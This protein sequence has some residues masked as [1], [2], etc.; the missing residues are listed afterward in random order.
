MHARKF[1]IQGQPA[2][3]GDIRSIVS[4]GD[5][6]SDTGFSD[7]HGFGRSSNGPTWVEY[8]AERL[9]ARLT[10]LAWGGART[11]QGNCSGPKDWSG[12]SWQIERHAFDGGPESTL[13]TI[14]A[15]VNDLFHGNGDPEA[16][17]ARLVA[18]QER[19]LEK[20][21]RRILLLTVPDLSRAPAY[22]TQKEYADARRTVH[23]HTL[24]VNARLLDRLRP[25]PCMLFD[26]AGFLEH[27]LDHAYRDT[28]AAWLGSYA[29][30]DPAGHFWWDDWHPMTSVHERLAQA[31][32]AA[33]D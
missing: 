20:G 5:S 18:A 13:Y 27:L 10:C 14:L 7:G 30:P 9:G 2:N 26:A 17:A 29:F 4:F 21:A 28:A 19:L 22:R 16:T 33:G 6:L 1:W 15:G 32:G 12:L 25:G 8:L 31:V 23:E 11:D 3:P 24:A